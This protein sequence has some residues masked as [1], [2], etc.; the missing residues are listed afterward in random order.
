MKTRLIAILV[1]L[2]LAGSA[3]AQRVMPPQDAPP[4]PPPG[5]FDDHV[6]PLPPGCRSDLPPPPH[7]HMPD[8]SANPAWRSALGVSD[9]QAAQVQQL[10]KQQA[11]KHEAEQ[12]QRRAED[13]AT[14]AKLRSIVSDKTMSRWE[15]ASMPPRPPM[16]PPA[17]MPPQP[18]QPPV[19]GQ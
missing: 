18:P 15:R 3:S 10:F 1:G 4:M 19:A 2:A 11:E 9:L 13:E 8:F 17:P 6:P 5:A 14:C 16:P 7:R 12:K